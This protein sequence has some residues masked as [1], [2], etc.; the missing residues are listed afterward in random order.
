MPYILPFANRTNLNSK[1]NA[2]KFKCYLFYWINTCDTTV[3]AKPFRKIHIHGCVCITTLLSYSLSVKFHRAILT[4][5][6]ADFSFRH[7]GYCCDMGFTFTHTRTHT[8]KAISSVNYIYY[9]TSTK[10]FNHKNSITN[11][12]SFYNI[13]WANKAN[14][15][16]L[17]CNLIKTE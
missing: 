3:S 4:K 8:K 12:I 10:W 7:F 5:S 6:Y 11:G 15:M 16:C 2:N 14:I 13:T 9:V 1:I 17:Y